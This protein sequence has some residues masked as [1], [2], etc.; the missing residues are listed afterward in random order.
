MNPLCNYF[1]SFG[2]IMFE[3][4]EDL[5]RYIKVLLNMNK[6]NSLYNIFQIDH[7]WNQI[8]S[9]LVYWVAYLPVQHTEKT[10]SASEK[11]SFLS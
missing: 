8:R 11:A 6:S 7:K 3:S 2:D 9:A 4:L 1:E 10:V 5:L